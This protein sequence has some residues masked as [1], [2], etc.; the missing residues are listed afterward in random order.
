[1]ERKLR[2]ASA[3]FLSLSLAAMSGMLTSCDSAGGLNTSAP[4]P[5][6]D[7]GGPPGSPPVSSRS[8]TTDFMIFTG[9]GSWGTEISDVEALMQAN[10]LSYQEAN[11]AQLD[12]M[13]PADLADFG[14]IYIPGG[15]GQ[16][17]ADS[18]SAATH[19]NLRTAVQSLGV[20]YVGFCAGAF[21]A[22]APAPAKGGDVS[23][24][25]GVVNGPLLN[26]Y[27]G[28]GTNQNYEMTL[29]SF[30]DGSTQ[31]ILWYGGPVTPNTGVVAKYPTGEPAISEI[32]SG[33]GLV[34][35]GG[36]HPDLSQASLASLGISPDTSS[37]DTALKILDAA[38]NRQP[39]PTF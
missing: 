22:V 35:I 29:E 16:T 18:V 33:N 7:A 8:Y 28:P 19:A 37:Q 38:L 31:N 1:M 4:S 14:V 12:Q 10:G 24:G 13:T 6:G 30:P 21:V 36:L 25:F 15:E 34:I 5:G 26:E 20:S 23:Y 27:A 3:L 39:L 17:E 32:W 11:S 2:A 9:S